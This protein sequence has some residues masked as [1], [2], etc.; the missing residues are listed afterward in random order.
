M[1]ISDEKKQTPN[2]EEIDFL[3][4]ERGGGAEVGGGNFIDISPQEL[5]FHSSESLDNAVD[6][7]SNGGN[8]LDFCKMYSIRV[9]AFWRWVEADEEKSAAIAAAEKM[10]E[11]VIAEKV[12]RELDRISNFD[13]RSIFDKSGAVKQPEEW[14]DDAG[15]VIAGMEVKEEFNREGE[16]VGYV[17]KVKLWDKTKTLEQV[18]RIKQMMAKEESGDSES[19]LLS[20]LRKIHDKRNKALSAGGRIESRGL[21]TDGVAVQAGSVVQASSV[22]QASSMVIDV[23]PVVEEKEGELL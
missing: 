2:S 1:D 11:R 13:I 20:I 14:S 21:H 23:T 22:S 18:A 8:I 3:I 10:K 9:S 12:F 15:S 5:F 16:L 6:H 17:K 4:G 19:D 7:I